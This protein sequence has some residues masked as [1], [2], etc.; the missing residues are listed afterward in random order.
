MRFEH[1]IDA[2]TGEVTKRTLTAEENAAIDAGIAA[3]I[4]EE[5]SRQEMAFPRFLLALVGR[6]V[7]TDEEALGWAG[8]AIPASI[9]STIN[10]LPKGD[11]L[12]VRLT[13]VQ[14][15]TVRRASSLTRLIAAKHQMTEADL[16]TLFADA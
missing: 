16:D 7:L 12:E 14:P 4:A 8:G 6:G 13:S 15:I 11:Q 9:L 3:A 1:I 5:R 10:L 2:V